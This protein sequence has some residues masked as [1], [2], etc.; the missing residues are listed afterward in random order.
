[1]LLIC[2]FN[3]NSGTI[4]ALPTIKC[5]RKSGAFYCCR[6]K[7]IM[8]SKIPS[9]ETVSNLTREE[10]EDLCSSLCS[11]LYSSHRVEDR[12]GKGNGLDAWRHDS[13][14]VEG[15]QFRRFNLRLGDSQAAQIKENIILARERS[16]L[17]IKKPLTRFTVIFNI[18]PEP[19]HKGK[20]GEI[21]RLSEIEEW[22]KETFDI[23]FYFLG[24]TWVRTQLIKFPMIKPDLGGKGTFLSI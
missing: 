8:S 4:Y 6:E 11:L 1:M 17:E 24:V 23:E 16:I 18:D 14:N 9:L 22:A 5:T 21:E 15:W 20:K 2:E 12:F 7:H 13:G 3:G 19:G 10:W